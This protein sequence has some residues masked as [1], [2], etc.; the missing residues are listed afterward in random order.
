[1]RA[2]LML[3]R[4]R[5]PNDDFY[6]KINERAI[7]VAGHSFGGFTALAMASGFHRPANS[8]DVPPD[9]RVK[10]IVPIAPASSSLSDAELARATEW[11][12]GLK[13]Q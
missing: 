11:V 5:D 1:M 12:R 8:I 10:A 7:G 6:A 9:R 13:I 4:N 2:H 3:T